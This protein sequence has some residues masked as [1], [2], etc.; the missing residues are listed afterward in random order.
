MLMNAWFMR[1]TNGRFYFKSC[2]AMNIIL[3]CTYWKAKKNPPKCHLLREKEQLCLLR[4]KESFPCTNLNK[5]F[6]AMYQTH[7]QTVSKMSNFNGWFFWNT[8]F[9]EDSEY[10]FKLKIS[11]QKPKTLSLMANNLFFCSGAVVDVVFK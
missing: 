9:T 6:F 2:M 8:K 11:N 3:R 1:H 7:L 10:S 4:V 5:I